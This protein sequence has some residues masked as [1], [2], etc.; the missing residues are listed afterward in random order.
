MYLYIHVL[1]YS[2]GKTTSLFNVYI[3][4]EFLLSEYRLSKHLIFSI[5]FYRPKITLFTALL[6]NSS[7][8]LKGMGVEGL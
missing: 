3:T 8:L 7:T 1:V 6:L 2:S 4:L 5:H